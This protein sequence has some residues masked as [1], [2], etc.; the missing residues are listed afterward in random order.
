MNIRHRA[1]LKASER[2]KN[3]IQQARKDKGWIIEDERW[4][5][6]ASKILEPQKNWFTIWETQVKAN[7]IALTYAEGISLSTWKRF[8]QAKYRIDAKTFKEAFCPVLGLN[9]EDV[10]ENEVERRKDLGKVPLLSKFY[11]R[12]QELTKLEQWLQQETYRLIVIYGVGG[13]GKSSLVRQVL[14]NQIIV[15]KYDYIFWR[16]LDFAP[17]L[18]EL[19]TFIQILSEEQESKADISQ[20]MRYLR[21]SKCLLILDAWE[22]IIGRSGEQYRDYTE[23]MERVAKEA[24]QSCVLLLSR[25]KP[26]FI[27]TLDDKLVHS[28]K[29]GGLDSKDVKDFLKTEGIY[30]TEKELDNFSL[31]YNNP[32]VMKRVAKKLKKVCGGK[33]TGVFGEISVVVDDAIASFLN[34]QFHRLSKLETNLLYWIAL[35]RN[36]ASLTQLRKDTIKSKSPL[37]A[38]ELLNAL[39]SL[40]DKFSLIEKSKN[41][42][43]DLDVY[44]LDLVILKYIT[45]QFVAQNCQEIL[46]ILQNQRIEGNELFVSHCFIT[47]NPEDEELTQQQMRRI[48]KAIQD[49][50]LAELLSQQQ[51]E[52]ELKKILSLLQDKELSPGYTYQNISY[53]IASCKSA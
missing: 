43:N 29:L 17:L 4:L 14:N 19:L 32:W 30:G 27:E 26:S 38:S 47:D 8:L 5:K 20:L 9:W 51:L 41:E 13:I 39:D 1:T 34:E 16:S 48:V 53:L 35:R 44:T 10:V 46:T 49:K 24:H 6:E 37:S 2:G 18:P 50:L 21:Q 45:N 23:L 12:T 15:N 22:E 31:T 25:E 3:L 11:G 28:L 33:I 42:E 7:S 52:D 40:I 36:S